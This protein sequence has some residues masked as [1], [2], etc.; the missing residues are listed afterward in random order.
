LDKISSIIPGN[1]RIQS[2]DDEG[3][4][5]ARPGSSTLGRH[6]GITTVHDR[7]SLSDAARNAALKENFKDTMGGARAKDM[8][9][10]KMVAEI[11]R[12]FFENRLK[13]VAQP[14]PAAEETSTAAMEAADEF[15]TPVKNMDR[16]SAREAIISKYSQPAFERETEAPISKMAVRSEPSFEEKS[17]EV[18]PRVNREMIAAE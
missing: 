17:V 10:A 14:S 12:N 3:S 18:E 4:Q 9:R 8:A 5:A 15:E 13:T 6:A 16:D 1:A 11:N 7:V 2:V